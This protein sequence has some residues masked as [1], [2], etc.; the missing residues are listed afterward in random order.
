MVDNLL[1][2]GQFSYESSI[3]QHYR[4]VPHKLQRY[5]LREEGER[6]MFVSVLIQIYN[7]YA[8]G[9]WAVMFNLTKSKN[10]VLFN[11]PLLVVI[12]A[13]TK[14]EEEDDTTQLS[15]IP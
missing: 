4:K 7:N 14:K 8:W 1:G 11:L 13:I 9:L 15:G 10:Q 2:Y 5:S 6:W 12:V 3:F